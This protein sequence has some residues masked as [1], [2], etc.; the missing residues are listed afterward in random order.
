[1]AAL[2]LAKSERDTPFKRALAVV[3]RPTSKL[4]PYARNSRTHS[5][6]QIAQI[7]GSIREFGFTNPVL[8]DEEGGIIAG[9]GRVLAAQLLEHDEV[10]TITLSHLSE[11]QKR[12]YVIAD[13]KLALNAGWDSEMLALEL[14][15]LGELGFDL[16]LTGFESPEI[17][18]LFNLQRIREDRD[19]D[20]APPVPV[21]VRSRPGDVWLCGAHKVACGDA[22]SMESWDLLMG[23]EKADAVWTDPPYN[24]DYQGGTV[25]ALK[26]KNDKMGDASFRAFLRDAFVSLFTVMKPGASIYV[27]HSDTEGLNFRGAFGEAGFKLSGCLIWRKNAMVLGRSDYQWMH[28]P[29]LYGWRP[30]AAHRW[31]GGRKNT[32]FIEGENTPFRKLEDGSYSV[33]VGDHVLHVSA[34]VIVEH[35]PSSVLFQDKPTRSAE[36]PTMKPVALVER[37]LGHCARAGDLV[38]DAFGGSGSTLIAADRLGMVARVMELDPRFVDVIVQRWQEYTGR[39]ATLGA[40]AQL[41]DQTQ[42][43]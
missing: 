30:G 22:C 33:T 7:A 6:A 32:T 26:I 28:E 14:H 12:A 15:D 9:H 40:T 16:A 34:D 21:K 24:V 23:P 42:A 27:A 25:D 39:Q 18:D 41:F 36:H 43:R 3:Y 13:N 5:E 2:Q 1:M 8:I 17:A 20:A 11:V 35:M 19:P 37:M 38:V 31:F 29:I 10:P 4:I